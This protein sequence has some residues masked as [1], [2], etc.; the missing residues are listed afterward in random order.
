MTEPGSQIL[1][2]SEG[3][4]TGL[5]EQ[6]LQEAH[7]TADA[8]MNRITNLRLT[9]APGEA[10][11]RG[12]GLCLLV[13]RNKCEETAGTRDFLAED[14]IPFHAIYV[15][16]GKGPDLQHQLVLPERGIPLTG[17]YN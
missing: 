12:L 17:S 5:I 11:K 6:F 13:H 9:R 1:L 4:V 10:L 15:Q 8:A 2:I 3:P 14:N 7:L 16:I